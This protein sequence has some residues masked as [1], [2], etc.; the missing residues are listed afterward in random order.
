MGSNRGAVAN[1]YVSDNVYHE[2]KTGY[3]INIHAGNIT[4]G[5]FATSIYF[6]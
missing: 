4:F 2:I 6:R 5:Y 3:N 1:H